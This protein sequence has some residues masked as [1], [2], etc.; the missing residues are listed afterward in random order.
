M[1][2]FVLS[3]KYTIEC[4]WKKTRNAFKHTAKLFRNDYVIYETK[5]CYLNRTW[6][7]FK[8]QSILQKVIKNCFEGKE[9]EK[10]LAIMGK[11]GKEKD[12]SFL[13]TAGMVAMFGDVFCNKEEDKNKW[14]KR[15]L[16]KVPG[17][18]FPDNFDKLPEKE[19]RRRLD[20]AIKISRE[21]I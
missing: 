11:E 6:E 2:K 10:F 19:K 20:G 21:K 14:K 13:K 16:S 15:M 5:I 17:I 12:N 7:A 8:Y 18:D 4:D 3:K 9:R 1:E